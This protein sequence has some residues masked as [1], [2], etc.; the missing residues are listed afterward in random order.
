MENLFFA[1]PMSPSQ[2]RSRLDPRPG[3]ET[4]LR[5]PFFR[6]TTAI[7]HSSA[8]RRMKHKTQVFFAPK[9][10]HICTRIEH[11]MHVATIASTVCRALNLDSDLAWAIGL[12]HD[13]GHTPFGHL[14]ET[15][16]ASLRG[17]AGFRH[18]MYS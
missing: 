2:L 13:L 10:D 8:F 17:K 5:G 9:N 4:D 18:E 12:G 7:I 16:L 14:G 3:E 1:N 15:I 6:D 11:V